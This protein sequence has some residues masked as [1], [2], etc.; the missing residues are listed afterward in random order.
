LQYLSF[1]LYQ[2]SI[3]RILTV[4]KQLY[5]FCDSGLA[6]RL[7]ALAGAQRI[8]DSTG[9]QL[10]VYWPLNSG[11]NA[12][13][14]RLFSNQIDFVDRIAIDRLLSN[15][16]RVK[17]YNS[18]VN[19]PPVAAWTDVLRDDLEHIVAIKSWACPKFKDESPQDA[20]IGMS[21]YLRRLKPA[22]E[23]LDLVNK[24][25][26]FLKPTQYNVGVHIRH[27]WNPTS[28]GHDQWNSHTAS[29]Y[30]VSRIEDF[31]RAMLAILS[32]RP[33]TK[34]FLSALNP[35]TE[36]L[37]K[38]KF[39]QDVVYTMPKSGDYS[40]TVLGMREALADLIMLSRTNFV[41]GTYWSQFSQCAAE[42][43][44]ILLLEVGTPGVLQKIEE[45]I[46]QN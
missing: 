24:Y 29:T 27:G 9:R 31:E 8:A 6:N 1:T 7:H 35:K 10:R 25:A 43:G 18:G 19:S 45:L 14:K 44:N 38:T 2:Y 4:V 11:L 17:F 42:Y 39:S 37:F 16:I 30:G 46:L 21:S 28:Y 41:L 22:P 26:D 12:K 20:Q 40:R 36:H 3:I 15:Q 13:F 32:Q 34:F 23:V 5:I 33:A